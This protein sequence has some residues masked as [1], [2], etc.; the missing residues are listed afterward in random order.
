MCTTGNV[1]SVGGSLVAIRRENGVNLSEEDEEDCV[2]AASCLAVSGAILVF[3]FGGDPLLST[4]GKAEPVRATDFLP[5][6]LCNLITRWRTDGGLRA[7]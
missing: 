2:L 1:G 3:A 4:G 6:S 7:L 5:K